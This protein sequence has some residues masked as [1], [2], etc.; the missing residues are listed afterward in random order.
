[1]ISICRQCYFSFYL[2]SSI[3]EKNAKT[4][5]SLAVVQNQGAGWL[6]SAID[7]NCCLLAETGEDVRE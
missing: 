1:M 2:L 3:T 5:F 7:A 4:V 6:T